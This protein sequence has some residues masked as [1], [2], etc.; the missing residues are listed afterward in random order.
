[1]LLN[2]WYSLVGGTPIYKLYGYVPH[3]RVW[4]MEHVHMFF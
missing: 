1:M 4:N 3:Y 2:P